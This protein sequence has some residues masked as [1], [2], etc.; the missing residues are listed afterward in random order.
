MYSQVFFILQTVRTLGL[1]RLLL[2]DGVLEHR[3]TAI[4]RPY[5][6]PPVEFGMS[7]FCPGLHLFHLGQKLVSK[8]MR[9]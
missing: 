7:S 1:S 5:V 4:H 9:I 3:S 8:E 2:L 6:R